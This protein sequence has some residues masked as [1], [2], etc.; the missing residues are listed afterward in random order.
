MKKIV[1]ITKKI[2]E[3]YIPSI[4]ISLLLFSFL[5]GIVSRYIVKNPQSWTYEVDSIA[6][7]I[8]TMTSVCL[9][10]H[11]NDHVVFDM[12]YNNF[13]EKNKCISRIISNILIIVFSMVLLPYSIKFISS[14]FGL[15]TQVIKIPRWIP[16]VTFP[17]VLCSSIIYSILRLIEDIKVFV[18]KTYKESYEEVNR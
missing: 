4:S 6:F 15:D 8:A 3:I 18:N 7:Y 2:I 5:V 1:D 14:M 10:N 9:V 12:F 13:S 11:T 17:I 16:F